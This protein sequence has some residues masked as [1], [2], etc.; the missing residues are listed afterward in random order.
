MFTSRFVRSTLLIAMFTG[1]VVLVGC[2]SKIELVSVSAG[3]FT[4]G[5]SGVGDDATCGRDNE[6]PRH[7]VTLSAYRIGKYDVTNQ[8][9]CDVLNWAA[10][11]GYLKD[12]GGNAW[13]GTGDIYGGGPPVQLLLCINASFRNIEYSGS[14]FSSK[15]RVG[16]PGSTNYSMATHPVVDVTW[17]GSV[18]FCNWL[19]EK[20]DLAPCYDLSTWTLTA[21]RSGGYRLP[22]EAEWERAAAWDG[23]KHWIYGFTSDTQ[24]GKN[25][26]NYGDV[27]PL[28]LTEEPYTCPVGWFDGVHVSPNG[29]IT[30][31]NSVS[32]VGCYDMSG[33]VWQWCQDW[34]DAYAASAVPDPQGPST[35]THQV[36]RGGCWGYNYQWSCRSAYR[37]LWGDEPTLGSGVFGFRVCSSGSAS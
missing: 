8:Q 7:E 26:C 22:T 17:Y 27:N 35:G 16:L 3:T 34:Y 28:G 33:N 15:S 13:A 29:N 25:W 10:G 9:Y 37:P 5:N 24:T 32:P 23:S 31:M 20:E 4:M 36:V 2:E 19:S 11:K 18:A 21:P 1:C 14:T 30:T 12:S 6:L